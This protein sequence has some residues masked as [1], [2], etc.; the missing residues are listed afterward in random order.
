[1]PRIQYVAFDDECF[2]T[3][4]EC[5]AYEEKEVANRKTSIIPEWIEEYCVVVDYNCEETT[6]DS[7]RLFDHMNTP[8]NSQLTQAFLEAFVENLSASNCA[9]LAQI[10][11]PKPT[12][13]TP[14]V[15]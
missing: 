9:Y 12:K 1:M 8:A 5:L 2:S 15:S 11:D 10:L 7:S 3:E 6:C 13:E 14:N 4:E